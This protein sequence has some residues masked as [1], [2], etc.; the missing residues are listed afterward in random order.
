MLATIVE[1]NLLR[2]IILIDVLVP[3]LDLVF[4]DH[5]TDISRVHWNVSK[6]SDVIHKMGQ[7]MY[8]DEVEMII[9]L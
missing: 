5:L 3:L 6:L 4:V 7:V 8:F 9:S 1:Q 2:G